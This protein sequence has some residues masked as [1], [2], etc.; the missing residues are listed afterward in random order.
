M[1]PFEGL[2]VKVHSVIWSRVFYKVEVIKQR[3]WGGLSD[4]PNH[5]TSL[6]VTCQ[7]LQT[8]HQGTEI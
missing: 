1:H 5:V 7:L 8:I 3:G 6:M 2:F 4:R